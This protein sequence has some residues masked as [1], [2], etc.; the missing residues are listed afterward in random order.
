MIKI[1]LQPKITLTADQIYAGTS[2]TTLDNIVQ[3]EFGLQNIKRIV[4]TLFVTLADRTNA[5]ET[6]NFYLTTYQKSAAGLYSRWDVCAFPQIAAVGPLYYT[7]ICNANPPEP[8][9]V[10]TAGPG[11]AA[12]LSGSLATYTAGAGNG[13]RV[14]T[15]GMAYHG[16]LGEGL[17]YSLV[18]GG[19]T[20]GPITYEIQVTCFQ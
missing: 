17:S 16:V 3:K 14:A 20:P 7:M 12:V 10:T 11:V 1:C 5:D 13:I 4:A 6:Y 19:S 9:S 8:L 15:A 2:H 18:A